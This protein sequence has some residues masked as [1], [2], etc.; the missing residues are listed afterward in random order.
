MHIIFIMSNNCVRYDAG[1]TL[2]MLTHMHTHIII[3]HIRIKSLIQLLI[4]DRVEVLFMPNG[5]ARI[6]NFSRTY[7]FRDVM[8]ISPWTK[9]KCTGKFVTESFCIRHKRAIFST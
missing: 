5:D 9:K 1:L 3:L 2:Y 6:T 7:S 4:L 8:T